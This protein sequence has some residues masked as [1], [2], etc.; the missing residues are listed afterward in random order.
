MGHCERVWTGAD[1]RL[2]RVCCAQGWEAEV[3]L[4]ARA[5]AEYKLVIMGGSPL[6]EEGGNRQLQLPGATDLSTALTLKVAEV[7]RG[8]GPAE[9]AAPVAR[10]VLL[11]CAWS[12]Q[13]AE[14]VDRCCSGSD[15]VTS[16]PPHCR[17]LPC[18]AC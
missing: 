2:T 4:P 17:S 14:V 11:D 10:Y 9:P 13:E 18:A 6:W 7:F 1:V 15:E 16:S 5:R 12:Q 3:A 8:E